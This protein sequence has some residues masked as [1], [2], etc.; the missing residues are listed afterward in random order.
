MAAYP[1][2]SSCAPNVRFDAR[3]ISEK[4]IY[5]RAGRDAV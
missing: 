2:G 4:M 5:S 1:K 3:S